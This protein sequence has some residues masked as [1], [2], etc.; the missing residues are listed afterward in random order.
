MTSASTT[1]DS[2]GTALLGSASSSAKL[3]QRVPSRA[4][5]ATTSSSQPRPS[6]STSLL[7]SQSD[8]VLDNCVP[9]TASPM[10]PGGSAALPPFVLAVESAAA[11][12]AVVEAPRLRSITS[13]RTS[14]MALAMSSVSSRTRGTGEACNSAVPPLPNASV[15]GNAGNSRSRGGVAATGNSTAPAA[16]LEAAEMALD[17]TMVL[18]LLLVVASL[19][20][21]GARCVSS[22]RAPLRYLSR[23]ALR[24]CGTFGSGRAP[25]AED[26]R[27][28]RCSWRW[29]CCWRCC[30]TAA[31]A[32]L[33]CG[34]DGVRPRCDEFGDCD[35][36]WACRVAASEA[37]AAAAATASR[38]VSMPFPRPG[39]PAERLCGEV[40]AI[41]DDAPMARR[42][43][44]CSALLRASAARRCPANLPFSRL[45]WA[46]FWRI[47]LSMPVKSFE[48]S[49]LSSWLWRRASHQ[50]MAMVS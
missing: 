7:L 22:R 30:R 47:T 18:S 27:G 1:L 15:C 42:L 23:G 29:D 39:V 24:V 17:S 25:V 3:S 20:T 38:N 31:G 41:G 44:A 48:P 11:L 33:R 2:G 28:R 50:P 43:P 6:I 16:L 49:L 26:A 4:I 36:A 34:G 5:D 45:A 19:A 37:G 32:R 40:V 8:D 14:A 35:R 9:S 10:A 12:P 21:F 46:A 13:R